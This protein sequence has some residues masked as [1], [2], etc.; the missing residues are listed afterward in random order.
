MELTTQQVELLA[1]FLAV[2]DTGD[3]R[4]AATKRDIIQ[5]Y[6]AR[7][8]EYAENFG[9]GLEKEKK[10]F[11]KRINKGEFLDVVEKEIPFILEVS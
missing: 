11:V 6:H 8:D 10:A 2:S 4:K 3:D 7:S 5:N 1:M 9:S